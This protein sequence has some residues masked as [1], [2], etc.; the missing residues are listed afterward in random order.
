MDRFKR[1]T[2]GREKGGGYV[3]A[4]VNTLLVEVLNRRLEAL[5]VLGNRGSDGS[6]QILESVTSLLN[7]SGNIVFDVEAHGELSLKLFLGDNLCAC[8]E[9]KLRE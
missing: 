8:Q 6:H 5:P 2:K 1:T 3:L 4:E 9:Q 7:Q